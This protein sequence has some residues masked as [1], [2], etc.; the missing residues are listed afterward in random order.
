[1]VNFIGTYFWLVSFIDPYFWLVKFFTPQTLLDTISIT[2]PKKRKHVFFY[3][4]PL[5]WHR[6]T[7][8]QTG[9]SFFRNTL[10]S[11]EGISMI[12]SVILRFCHVVFE[13]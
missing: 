9:F 4:W 12:R 11:V 10:P 8:K 7:N 5:T 1:L 2:Q 6:Q 3:L 13:L